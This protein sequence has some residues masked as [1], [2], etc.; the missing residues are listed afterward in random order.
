MSWTNVQLARHEFD[1]DAN[2]VQ[3]YKRNSQV[4]GGIDETNDLPF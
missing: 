2:G 3:Y 1:D 4:L